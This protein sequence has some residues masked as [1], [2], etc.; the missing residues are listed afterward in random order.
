MIFFLG[1]KTSYITTMMTMM[2]LQN[3]SFM[4]RMIDYLVFSVALAIGTLFIQLFLLLFHKLIS[5]RKIRKIVF[6]C[7]ILLLVGVTIFMPS[8]LTTYFA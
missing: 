8:F 4:D 3:V 2:N 1:T 5:D 7:I 6:T